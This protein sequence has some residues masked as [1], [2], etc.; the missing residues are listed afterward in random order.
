MEAHGIHAVC[1]PLRYRLVS[2]FLCF[3]LFSS[4]VLDW[5]S[6]HFFPLHT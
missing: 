5:T 1:V 2:Y 6:H 3:L 4:H